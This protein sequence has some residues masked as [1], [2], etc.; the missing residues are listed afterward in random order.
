MGGALFM[1]WGGWADQDYRR[2]FTHL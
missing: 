2:L 1:S